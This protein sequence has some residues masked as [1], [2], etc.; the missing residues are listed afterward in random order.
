MARKEGDRSAYVREEH[1]GFL[2]KRFGQGGGQQNYA[3]RAPAREG[4]SDREQKRVSK[5]WGK[6]GNFTHEKTTVKTKTSWIPKPT[7]Q[8]P[9]VRQGKTARTRQFGRLGAKKENRLGGKPREIRCETNL[10]IALTPC[11]R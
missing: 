8:K 11:C 2:R 9:T 6:S 7:R 5:G 3:A 10:E 1:D 4:E